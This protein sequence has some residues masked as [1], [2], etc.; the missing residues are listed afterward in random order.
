MKKIKILFINPTDSFEYTGMPLGLISVAT[1]VRDNMSSCCVEI[2]D[3]DVKELRKK[4]NSFQPDIIG[5]YSTIVH[6][7][8]IKEY[9]R[10]IRSISKKNRRDIKIVFGGPTTISSVED[11]KRLSPDVIIIGEGETRFLR[12]AKLMQS[13]KNAEQFQKEINSIGNII[14]HKKNKFIETEKDGFFEN[15][16][17]IELPDID[18]VDFKK[19]AKRF[20]YF[21][22]LKDIKGV[23]MII[24]RGCSFNCSFCQPIL[25]NLFGNRIR[26]YDID[27]IISY[28]SDLKRKHGINAIFFHDDTFT[29]DK[30]WTK[31]FC[32]KMIKSKLNVHWGCNSRVD[33]IDDELVKI[34]RKAGCVEIRLGIESFNEKNLKFLNKNINRDNIFKSIEIIKNNR[35]KAFAFM[36]IGCPDERVS[37]IINDLFRLSFSRLDMARIS[38]LTNL[39]GTHLDEKIHGKYKNPEYC[40]YLKDSRNNCSRIPYPLLEM[41]KRFG[42][43]IFYANPIRW[44][45][46]FDM[47]NSWDKIKS[48][49]ERL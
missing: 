10:I 28:I 5:I 35:M 9:V 4:V 15:L 34:M 18:L 49:F 26:R 41:L 27:K 47:L 37:E 29:V 16:N 46:T 22:Y 48:K 3:E 21:D 42:H 44:K 13:E 11:L 7:N 24:S 33:T 39:P 45:M 8:K 36:I 1:H 43:I 40:N 25:R 14:Y 30:A 38:I 32:R 17:K 12:Y 31:E 20:Y 23:Q 6:M 2:F 19:Y